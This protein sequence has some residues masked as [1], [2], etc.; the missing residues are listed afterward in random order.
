M[1]NSAERVRRL[2]DRRGEVQ[3]RDVATA[4]AVSPAS[5]HRLLQALVLSGTLARHGKGRAARY[6]LRTVRRRFPPG[7]PR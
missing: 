6:R 1:K 2:V 4:L 5:A 7:G 3:N